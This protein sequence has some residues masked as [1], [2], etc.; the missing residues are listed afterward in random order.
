V[1]GAASGH[2][3]WRKLSSA[4]WEDVW[5]E[6]LAAL[7]DRLAITAFAGRKTIRIE[8]FALTRR[9]ADQLVR[10]FGGEAFPQKKDV[11]L[12]PQTRAPIRVRGKLI[13]VGS[14][15]ERAEL[16]AS[17]QPVLL[18]PAGMAF[19]T[20]DHATTATCLR[21]LADVSDELRGQPW[22]MLDLGCGTAILGLAGRRFG[23]R[24]VDAADFDPDAVRV[25]KENV[26]ANGL[27]KITVRK[28]DVRQWTPA[29]TWEV[30]V[31]NLFSGLLV[32]AA[33]K[34]AA[35]TAP[36]GRLIFSGVIRAQEPEVLAAFQANGFH[37]TRLVR[38]GKWVAGAATLL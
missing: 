25:A 30:I 34:I 8:A 23:A 28:L 14:E 19:G 18:I 21:L 16:S 9:Q 29:R 20:G 13:V 24:R 3:V 7:R 33:P 35:A 2:F 27:D 10:D 36:G 4:K 6:R 38:K 17:D 22:E 11:A 1:S 12:P 31:A 37:L 32:E 5:P 26:R 15:R